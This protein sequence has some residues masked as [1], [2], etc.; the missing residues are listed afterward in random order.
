MNLPVPERTIPVSVLR[1]E[2]QRMLDNGEL[3]G[4]DEVMDAV[5]VARQDL[6]PAIREAQRT[7]KIHVVRKSD[8]T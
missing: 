6:A 2:A 1:R 4:L 5:A 8:K 3:P 7:A